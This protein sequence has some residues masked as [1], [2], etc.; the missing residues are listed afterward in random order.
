MRREEVEVGGELLRRRVLE[1][2]VLITLEPKHDITKV[3][4][5]GCPGY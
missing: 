2:V 5:T 1:V 4:L 3:S